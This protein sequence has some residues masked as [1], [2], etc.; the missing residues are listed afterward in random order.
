[1]S[2]PTD[3][4]GES[5]HRAKRAAAPPP[6]SAD[7]AIV[8]ALAI[9]V[10]DLVDKL[11]KVRK[12]QAAAISVIEGELAGKIVVIVVSGIGRAAARRA[13][14]LVIA[15]HRPTVLISA[16]FAG[17]LAQDLERNELIIPGE[18][19]DLENQQYRVELPELPAIFPSV[20]RGRLVTVDQLV[21]KVS[22]KAALRER[23][24]ADLVDMESSAVAAVCLPR[25]IPFVP[26][27]IVSDDA[28][29]ELP[30]EIGK[31]LTQSGSYRVGFALRT[32][33]SRP[34]SLK[35]F[36]AL[37]ERALEA[38]DRLAKAVIKYV[39]SLRAPG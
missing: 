38:S 10:G 26:I 18:V 24:L 36:W 17:A 30:R 27:R 23:T 33:W 8:A 32:I 31:M 39:E 5:V 35:D 6:V 3:D 1:M 16:G 13:A 20:K 29:T 4:S 11:R 7:V 19:I 25:R 34:S 12:Y 2:Q 14:D 22:E 9:E 37:H 15:G 28:R 21:L